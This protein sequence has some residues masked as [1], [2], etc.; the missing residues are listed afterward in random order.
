MTAPDPTILAAAIKCA[1]E[2]L[3]LQRDI[4][5][6]EVNK[7]RALVAAATAYQLMREALQNLAFHVRGID[8]APPSDM[9]RELIAMS[10]ARANALLDGAPFGWQPVATA[11]RDETWVL[12]F[13]PDTEGPP[14]V[15]RWRDDLDDP[16]GGAWWEFGDL[17]WPV[18]ADATHWQPLPAPPAALN[19][20]GPA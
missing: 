7:V 8:G 13:S 14:F 17:A 2:D 15:G 5:D 16:D 11:P 20:A 6:P 4:D 9:Q 1:S 12:L 10:A 19:P 3:H 18:D